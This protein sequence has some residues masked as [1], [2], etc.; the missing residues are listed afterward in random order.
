MKQVLK[1]FIQVVSQLVIIMTILLVSAGSIK[2]IWAWIYFILC[3][4]ILI[5]NGFV[6]DPDLIAERGKKK[7]NIK[8]F[9]RII[10]TVNIIPVI[11]IILLSGLDKRFGWTGNTAMVYYLAGIILMILGNALFTWA[12]VAN[13]YFSTSVRIQTDRDHKVAEGGPYTIV[14]HP[15]YTGY[16]LFTF[17]TPMIL[18]SLWALIPAGITMALFVI[19]TILEDKTLQN[20]LEGY[21]EY[22]ARVKYRLVPGIF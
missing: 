14:R 7:E 20:E 12:M 10:T 16:I 18:G 13:K 6:L 5:V 2:W 22:A 19:R 8:K 17:A 1:R 15:G 4:L 3:V 11:S 9:D 21:R